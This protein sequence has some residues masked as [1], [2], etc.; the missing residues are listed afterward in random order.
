[1][2]TLLSFFIIHVSW[3][4]VLPN[5]VTESSQCFWKSNTNSWWLSLYDCLAKILGNVDLSTPMVWAHKGSGEAWQLVSAIHG[6]VMVWYFMSGTHKVMTTLM[7]VVLVLVFLELTRWLP[8]KCYYADFS[9]ISQI[10]GGMTFF[11]SSLHFGSA[12]IG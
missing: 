3:V 5:I 4:Q 2:K 10:W 9:A 8:S 6:E 1:M 11:L 12:G 7:V